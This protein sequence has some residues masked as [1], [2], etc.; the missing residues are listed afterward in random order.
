MARHRAKNPDCQSSC[1]ATHRKTV[2]V[3]VSR[4]SSDLRGKAGQGTGVTATV[5][6]IPSPPRSPSLPEKQKQSKKERPEAA[7]QKRSP[8]GPVRELA[9]FWGKE[10]KSA[11]VTSLL[12]P[13]KDLK[14]LLFAACHGDV[15]RARD[16]V[17]PYIRECGHTKQTPSV[18]DLLHFAE[19]RTSRRNGRPPGAS[20]GYAGSALRDE[21]PGRKML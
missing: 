7:E 10:C 2:P 6:G 18:S 11:G 21:T 20:V 12:G 1:C 5:T 16:L 4:R 14:T 3:P 9:S 19:S 15:N 8:K 13:W 17:G